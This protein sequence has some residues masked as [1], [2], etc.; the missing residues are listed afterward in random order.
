MT[1][2]PPLIHVVDDDDSLRSALLRLLGARCFDTRA[3]ASAKDALADRHLGQPACLVGDLKLPAMSG[4][5]LVDHLRRRGVSAPVVAITGNDEPG[6]REE[7]R[8]R[9]IEHVLA[10]P[11]L[12]SAVVALLDQIVGSPRPAGGGNG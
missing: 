3:F 9:G 8:R 5:D 4:L 1:M 2:T 11:F 12:G 7:V 10:K 6:V